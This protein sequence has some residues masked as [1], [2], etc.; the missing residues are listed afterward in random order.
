M[1]SFPKPKFPYTLQFQQE[2]TRLRQARESNP[3]LQI[4]AASNTHLLIATW[5]IANFGE[6]KREP[7]H[8]KII[9]EILSWF[10]L[11]AVQEIKE[12]YSILREY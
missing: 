6:Q 5:N 8:L 3:K 9:A 10:D 2:L 12:N 11:V 4:P 7:D 1:P